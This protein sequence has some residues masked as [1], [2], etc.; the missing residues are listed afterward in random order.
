MIPSRT[1]ARKAPSL[2][3]V[4]TCTNLLR[5]Q[6]F[7]S[8][9]DKIEIPKRIQ[10]GPTDILRALEATI[11]RDPTAAHYKYHDD[12]YL[13]PMSNVG[14]RAFALAKNAGRKAAH[15]VRRQHPD[16]FN[17]R[18][19]DPP[20]ERFFPKV[21]YDEN[22]ELAEQDL[23]DAMEK[24]QVSD[25]LLI[26]KI[27]QERNADI[28]AK[29]TQALLELLCY[30]NSQD[31]ID[32]EWLEER[33]FRQSV[34][35]QKKLWK[36][37][38]PAEEVFA[39]LKEPDEEAYAALIQGMAKYSQSTRAW[40]YFEEARNK[41]YTLNTDTYNSLI[42][43][44]KFF[45]EG[46]DM[47]WTHV[48]DLL[49]SMNQANLKP[50]LGTLNAVLFVLSGMTTHRAVKENILKTLREFKNL[51]I[52]PSLG[53]YYFIINTFY[54]DRRSVSTVLYDVMEQV[55]NKKHE[56]RDMDDTSFFV[57]AMDICNNHLR[58]A[59]LAERVNKLLHLGNNY[60]LIGD[61]YRESTYYRH[62]FT[63]LMTNQPLNE[64]ME[65]VYNKLVPNIYVPEP[66][67]MEELLRQVELNASIEYIPKLWSDMTIF[68]QVNREKLITLVL[69]IMVENSPQV[70]TDLAIAFSNIAKNIYENI[71]NQN[72]E[73]TN[74]TVTGEMLGN[75][76]VLV[77]A[78][79]DFTI[80]QHIMN[81]LIKDHTKVVG[82]PK[83]EALSLFV[84]HCMAHSAPS[85]AIDCIQYCADSGFPEA[86]A[87]SARLNSKM[88]LDETMLNRLSPIISS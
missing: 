32:E 62:Y 74:L 81:K 13:L 52:E 85:S 79:N 64:F 5:K 65:N 44:S 80:A 67:V 55:D 66:S 29:S 31:D 28:S 34:K 36:D 24:N 19:C 61:S 48:T 68:D 86:V 50:N 53:S 17:H 40:H 4:T 76:M 63:V 8:E 2:K 49:R 59:H 73:R 15:W 56:I 18:E 30:Y 39:K 57:A 41:G 10:R 7:S 43:I 3:Q 16:V 45:K 46:Y 23:T 84:D 35:G 77:L 22:S 33:W 47:R 27:L 20:I 75:I 72:P 71:E 25:S 87:L 9:M 60:N 82:V 54:G 1:L 83:F 69:N 88:T 12:P 51:E 78:N 42:R 21:V 14:K 26:Y 58:D 11:S 38:G 37:G 70:G 6:A